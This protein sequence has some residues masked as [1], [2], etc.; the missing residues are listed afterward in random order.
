MLKDWEGVER[1]KHAN[2]CRFS[3]FA[4]MVELGERVSKTLR[5][6]PGIP[7]FLLKG[8][9]L[10]YLGCGLEEPSV[11]VEILEFLMEVLVRSG[12]RKVLDSRAD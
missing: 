5:E 12:A 9:G 3:E 1:H 6:S 11:H 4:D 8:H 2:G 7:R 10:L